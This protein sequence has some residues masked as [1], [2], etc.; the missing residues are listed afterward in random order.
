MIKEK[1]SV[2]EI[3]YLKRQRKDLFDRAVKERVE[4][5]AA[6]DESAESRAKVEAMLDDVEQ[7]TVRINDEERIL[8]VQDTVEEYE[9]ARADADPTDPKVQ[10]S[11]AFRSFI[12]SGPA[13]MTPEHRSLLVKNS[14]DTRAL[15]VAS[16]GVGGYVVPEDFYGQ[17]V[18]IMKAYGGMRAAGATSLTTSGGN[19][20][21]VPKGDDTSNT[22]EIVTEG[23][24]VNTADPTFTQMILKGYLYSSK[25]VRVGVALLQD[26]AV[27]LES[28]L[29]N[30]LAT[31][32]GRITN[33]HFTTGDDTDKP[34]GVLNSAANSAVTTASNTAITYEELVSLMHSVDPAYQANGRFMLNDGTLAVLKKMKT[35]TE[36][37]PL[38][39]PGVAA[40]EADTILGKP[41]VVNQDMPNYAST[42]KPILFGDFSQYFI[43]DVSGATMMRL[44][45]RYADY[46]QVGFMLFSR[47]DG[48]LA[49]PNAIKYLT[50][51]A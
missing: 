43:R 35:A 45:E 29:A 23:S 49:V 25:I 26:E 17:I 4:L 16:G 3:Q 14:V 20:L 21:P 11:D 34:D 50:A 18:D 48:G 24:A 30:W 9:E 10:Y 42:L 38:W 27:N 19:D 47:H 22:G 39:L 28:L 36:G 46:L 8:A 32:I 51:A 7:F 44:T 12:R 37:I 31:R 13:E 33:T 15:G 40:R 2:A 6:G 41:Y 1:A 5:K